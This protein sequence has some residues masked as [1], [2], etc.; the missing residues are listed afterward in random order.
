M[1]VRRMKKSKPDPVPAEPHYAAYPERINIDDPDAL[2]RWSKHF[3]C[4]TAL[5]KE[6]VFDMGDDPKVIARFMADNNAHPYEPHD[7]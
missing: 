1:L 5:L 3:G 6:A 4:T 2:A 7:P